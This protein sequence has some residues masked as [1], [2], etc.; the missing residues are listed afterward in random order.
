MRF[1]K[2]IR[3]KLDLNQYKMGQQLGFKNTQS[4]INFENAKYSINAEKMIRLWQLSGLTAEE[5][6]QLIAKDVEKNK[7]AKS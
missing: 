1:V 6:L 4:Y 2:K 5:L 3:K 7:R